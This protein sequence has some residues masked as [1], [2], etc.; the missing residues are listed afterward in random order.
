[1]KHRELY[2]GLIRIHILYHANKEPLYGLWLIEELGRHGYKISP[3]TL[4]PILHNMEK[5]G[6]LTSRKKL[7]GGKYR[8][9]YRITEE[10]RSALKAANLKVRELFRELIEGK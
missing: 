1:M 3:G 7:H 2:S 10:G 6:Y 9:V 5:R 8:R 4:Y